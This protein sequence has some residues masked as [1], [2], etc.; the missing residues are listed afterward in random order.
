MKYEDQKI[1]FMPVNINLNGKEVLIIGG[2][3]VALQKVQ[4][5]SLYT[6]KIRIVAKEVSQSIKDL[7]ISYTEKEYESIDLGS[8]F[9][10]YACTDCKETNMNILKDAQTAGILVNVTDNPPLSDFVSPAVIN[11][12]HMTVAVGSNG[13]DVKTAIRWRDKI[14]EYLLNNPV[15]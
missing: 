2:G 8:S 13:Q 4:R 6:S 1:S 14:K 10:V 5:I 15:D 12:G 9:L 3:K 7:G 11:S